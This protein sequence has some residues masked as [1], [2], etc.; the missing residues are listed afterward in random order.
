[1]LL[2]S[3]IID[4]KLVLLEDMNHVLKTVENDDLALNMATYTKPKLPLAPGLVSAI[5]DFIKTKR[6]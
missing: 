4:A 3:N 1:Q 5:V 6:A 2:K